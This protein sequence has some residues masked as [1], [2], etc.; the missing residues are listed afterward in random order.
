MYYYM[1]WWR[2]D[3]FFSDTYLVYYL[4]SYM[5]VPLN[6][7]K[8]K[9]LFDVKCMFLKCE[10]SDMI[11]YLILTCLYVKE[12][13]CFKGGHALCVFKRTEQCM[14]WGNVIKMKFFHLYRVQSSCSGLLISYQV[15]FFLNVIWKN[16][17]IFGYLNIFISSGR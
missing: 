10:N 2:D 7:C 12:D 4:Y 3:T 15:T 1:W 9:F 16:V 13:V 8:N 14:Y 17:Q 11:F 6:S 5:V